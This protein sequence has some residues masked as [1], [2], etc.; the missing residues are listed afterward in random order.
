M[1]LAKATSANNRTAITSLGIRT[2]AFT[3]KRKI[4]VLLQRGIDEGY[5]RL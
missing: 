3:K 5:V 1:V 2:A 4:C